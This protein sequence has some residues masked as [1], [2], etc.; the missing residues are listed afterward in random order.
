MSDGLLPKVEAA[1]KKRNR[2]MADLTLGMFGVPA[3]ESF[4]AAKLEEGF[5]HLVFGLPPE[6]PDTVLPLLD[7][8]AILAEKMR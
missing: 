3:D 7:Q 2:S 5:S 8:Y 1:L 6:G 4:I